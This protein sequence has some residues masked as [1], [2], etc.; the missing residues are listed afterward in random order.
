[1]RLPRLCAG[2]G[3]AFLLSV[4]VAPA[5]YAHA[6]YESSDPANQS[7]VANP[8]SSVT[9]EFTEPVIDD[10][11]LDV[12][13]PCGSQVDNGDSFVAA[14][15]ITVSMSAD[16]Q[17]TYTVRFS[18]VS[19]V[20]SHPTNGEFTFTSTGG[21][22]CPGEEPE[23]EEPTG[24]GAGGGNDSSGSGDRKADTGGETTSESETSTSR[25][26]NDGA[27]SNKASEATGKGSQGERNPDGG[28]DR[29]GTKVAG[30]Q[31]KNTATAIGPSAISVSDVKN[32]WE[33]IPLV[34]FI[35]AMLVAAAIGGAGGLVYAGI[36]GPK[37]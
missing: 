29:A 32:I 17:G 36:M 23:E 35:V 14:D 4:V 28:R 34:G 19:A 7:T 1:M 2:L 31:L 13:D 21:A 9:A 27:G 6:A 16:K 11:R 26:G 8:P 3:T 10:S 20:D 22:P 37:R 5:A 12:F 30:K 15:R 18:V 24:G 33:G 25:V